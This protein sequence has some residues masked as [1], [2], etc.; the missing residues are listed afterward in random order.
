MLGFLDKLKSGNSE[1]IEWQNAVMSDKSQKLYVNKAQ[2][3]AVTLQMVSD[4]M[5]IFDD[6]ASIINSTTKPDVFFS[7]L[8]LAEEKLANLVRIEPYIKNVKS[9]T[10]NKS[11]S[12]SM[13]EFQENRNRYIV[14]FLYRYYQSV[15][16][17]AEGMKTEKGKQNQ[18]I[19]FQESLEPYIYQLND[20]NKKIFESMCQQ[21]I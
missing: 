4:N 5:R 8:E 2:L 14:D 10:V 21:K 6:S 12:S 9:I 16:D 11:L 18:F 20:T 17:K 13:K 15:K 3:E 7:R 19:K 1:L